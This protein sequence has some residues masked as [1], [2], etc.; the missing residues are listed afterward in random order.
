MNTLPEDTGTAYRIRLLRGVWQEKRQA[1]R[2]QQKT[3]GT[4]SLPVYLESGMELQ[5]RLI[6]SKT[7]TIGVTKLPE[8]SAF[9]RCTMFA[10]QLH[11]E[12]RL[13]GGPA[14]KLV[15]HT[16]GH[17]EVSSNE[18]IFLLLQGAASGAARAFCAISIP[19]V[20]CT[21]VRLAD[22]VQHTGGACRRSQTGAKAPDAHSRRKTAPTT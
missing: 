13:Q 6:H 11:Q 9:P 8:C 15:H 19:G 4:P 18:L 20:G 2:T 12:R 16:T 3:P 17:K 7:H 10:V 14:W 21:S 5:R 22:P 1:V